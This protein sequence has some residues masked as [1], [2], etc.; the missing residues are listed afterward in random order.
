MLPLREQHRIVAKVDKFMA[1]CDALKARLAD[2][3][4]EQSVLAK[5]YSAG[6]NI[7]LK[8]VCFTALHVWGRSSLFSRA[9]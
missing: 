9:S 5:R 1:L 8:A 2:A 4:V 6:P 7:L 3:I